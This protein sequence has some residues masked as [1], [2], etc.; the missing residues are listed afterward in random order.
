[1]EQ[2]NFSLPL[3]NV[4]AACRR[5]CSSSS[6]MMRYDAT[7]AVP[8]LMSSIYLAAPFFLDQHSQDETRRSV[9]NKKK[10]QMKSEKFLEP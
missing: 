9:V 5:D 4:D 10:V 3:L 6:V 2:T 7:S 8:V 1:M